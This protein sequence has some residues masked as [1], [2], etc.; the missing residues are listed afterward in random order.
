M[1]KYVEYKFNFN[2]SR[3][4]ANDTIPITHTTQ[5]VQN[6]RKGKIEKCNWRDVFFRNYERIS[7]LSEILI[8]WPGGYKFLFQ[9][10]IGNCPRSW[11]ENLSI[12]YSY[13]CWCRCNNLYARN[14]IHLDSTIGH[15]SKG[16]LAWFFHTLVWTLNRTWK[17]WLWYTYTLLL[18][19]ELN[20]IWL[21]ITSANTNVFTLLLSWR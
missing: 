21:K 18:K 19:C 2:W 14:S 13:P 17:I 6:Y 11:N 4:H 9:Y 8:I 16:V 3:I 12:N 7:F 15:T 20:R 1:K 5:Y 10:I